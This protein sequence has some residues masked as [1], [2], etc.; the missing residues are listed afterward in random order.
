MLKFMIYTLLPQVLHAAS[1]LLI[2][3]LDKLLDDMK[4]EADKTP[5]PID[6]ILVD[7]LRGLLGRR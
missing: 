5:N 1:P 4:I 2:E 7:L 6:N 3:R